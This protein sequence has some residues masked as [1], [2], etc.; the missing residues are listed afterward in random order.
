M[1]NP[2]HTCSLPQVSEPPA[3]PQLGKGKECMLSIIFMA[4]GGLM[5]LV[6]HLES[7]KNSLLERI[8]RVTFAIGLGIFFLGYFL[9]ALY[10]ATY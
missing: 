3:T 5:W 1:G 2:P 10:Y 8:G 6:G 4:V 9:K 7:K